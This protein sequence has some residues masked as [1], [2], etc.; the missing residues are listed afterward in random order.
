M[1]LGRWGHLGSRLWAR[2]VLLCWASQEQPA[3]WQQ[4]PGSRPTPCMRRRAWRV[5]RAGGGGL[6]ATP[7]PRWLGRH[8][9]LSAIRSRS[10]DSVRGVVFYRSVVWGGTMEGVAPMCLQQLEISFGHCIS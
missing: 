7:G 4:P 1:D 3:L 8:W 9:L 2:S 10:P 5:W 6:G